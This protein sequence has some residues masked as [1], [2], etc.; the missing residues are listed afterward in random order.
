MSVR[1]FRIETSG[2]LINNLS[3]TLFILSKKLIVSGRSDCDAKKSCRTRMTQG[4][5]NM[6]KAGLG[7]GIRSN[8]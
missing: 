1:P 7:P 2:N 4:P 3:I 5:T 6:K 8:L